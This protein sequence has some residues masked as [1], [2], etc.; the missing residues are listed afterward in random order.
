MFAQV[1]YVLTPVMVL[2]CFRVPLSLLLKAQ[3]PL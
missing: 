2:V 1:L 3:G